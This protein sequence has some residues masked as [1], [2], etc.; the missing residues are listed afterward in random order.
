MGTNYLDRYAGSVLADLGKQPCDAATTQN[1]TLSGYQT[2]DGVILN[3]DYMRVLVKNQD[4]Q[5]QNGLYVVFSGL[6]KRSADFTGPT[7]TVNGQLVAV[8]GGQ[9]AGLWQ[10]VSPNP[11]TIDGNTPSEIIFAI[12]LL[13]T[14]TRAIPPQ[15]QQGAAGADSVMFVG[16][17]EFIY[18]PTA[19]FGADGSPLNCSYD[20]LINALPNNQCVGNINYTLKQDLSPCATVQTAVMWAQWWTVASGASTD[21]GGLQPAMNNITYGNLGSNNW[22]VNGVSAASSLKL[23][24]K[25]GG[26]PDDG[27]FLAGAQL[28]AARGYKIGL[29]P[30]TIGIDVDAGVANSG[31]TTWRGFFS[32]PDSTTFQTWC[33]KYQALVKHYFDMLNNAGIPIDIIYIGTEMQTLSI[34]GSNAIWAI[35]VAALQSLADYVKTNSPNTK[36]TYA[37]NWSEYG[38]GSNFRLDSLWTYKNIDYVGVDW[39]PPISVDTYD[40]SQTTFQANLR[41]GEQFDYIVDTSDNTQHSLATTR[42]KGKIGLAQTPVIAAQS[43]KDLHAFF[44][45]NHYL[46]SNG[47]TQAEAT[48]LP[49]YDRTYNP[50]G[51]SVM[52]N[53]PAFG[54]SASLPKASGSFGMYPAPTLTDTWAQFDGSNV[55][56]LTLPTWSTNQYWV[57]LKFGFQI[58]NASP[59]TFARLFRIPGVCECEIDISGGDQVKIGFGNSTEDF[60]NICAID[61]N[62]HTVSVRFDVANLQVYLSVDGGAE[63]QHAVT[64]GLAFTS[65]ATMYV[66]GYDTGNNKLQYN[67]YYLSLQYAVGSAAT[68]AATHGGEFFFDESYCGVRTAWLPQQKQISICEV[69]FASMGGTGVEPNVFPVADYGTPI[70]PPDWLDAFTKAK[71]KSWISLGWS[72]SALYGPYGSDFSFDEIGQAT[73]LYTTVSWLKSLPFVARICVYAVDARPSA[74]MLAVYQGS[75]YY[76][77]GPL[78]KLAQTINGKLVGGVVNTNDLP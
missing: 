25:I 47:T 20:K 23:P 49:G 22:S 68:T 71:Y 76:I 31:Q 69:G 12:Y 8:T 16:F 48:P 61:T 75:L 21:M 9:N 78:Y 15:L 44:F 10:L 35:W 72:P 60:L 30:V 62:Y 67:L 64:H 45:N 38:N 53:V 5:T 32:W 7:G 57:Y 54:R 17:D 2:I 29:V 11:I 28:L 33:T 19:I 3:A 50:N 24:G 37:A 56:S 14:N 41:A 13:V 42:R 55:A 1:I 51:I 6:W 65:A 52:G 34:S 36:V 40:D 59:T 66:A 70:T 4:D 18:N 77:D 63:V 27:A 39:Y 58:T 43:Q 74:T 73:A 46:S 26:T